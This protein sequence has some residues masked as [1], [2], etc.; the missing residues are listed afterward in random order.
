MGK[1]NYYYLIMDEVKKTREPFLI[2]RDI[3]NRYAR[4]LLGSGRRSQ[5]EHGFGKGQARLAGA[6]RYARGFRFQCLRLYHRTCKTSRGT[7]KITL[8]VGGKFGV[9][10]G[11]LIALLNKEHI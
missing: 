6:L 7:K 8:G 1:F 11:R 5:G 3:T 4:L 2:G 10:K 9:K